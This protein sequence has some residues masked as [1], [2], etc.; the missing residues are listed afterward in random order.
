L[1]DEGVEA[2]AS[3][4]ENENDSLI[5]TNYKIDDKGDATAWL[6]RMEGTRTM[7]KRVAGEHEKKKFWDEYKKFQSIG[8]HGTRDWTSMAEAWNSFVAGREKTGDNEVVKYY[9]KHAHMLETFF[10]SGSK[11]NNIT[12]TLQPHLKEI[13]CLMKDHRVPVS[14]PTTAINAPG[15]PANHGPNAIS[16][17]NATADFSQMVPLIPLNMSSA[18]FLNIQDRG[19]IIYPGQLQQTNIKIT[20]KRML[21]RALQQC[22]I[23]GHFRQHNIVFNDKHI[24]KCTVTESDYST[25]RSLKG[26]CPCRD[27]VTGADIVGYCKPIPIVKE[28]R[29]LKTCKTCGHYKHAGHY[30]HDHTNTICKVTTENRCIERHKGFC[31]CNNCLETVLSSDRFKVVKQRKLNEETI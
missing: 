8:E 31:P 14:A 4:D 18:A 25:D 30:K 11:N 5:A 3:D 17:A 21:E 20:K 2:E 28:I 9:R 22:I 16:S 13:E 10:E 12:A 26:W 19:P 23:C 27:C 1:K 7:A 15:P 29:A 6:A 24:G